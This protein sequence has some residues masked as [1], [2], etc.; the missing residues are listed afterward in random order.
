MF[1]VYYLRCPR[2]DAVKYV[3]LTSRRTFRRRIEHV[4]S[5]HRRMGAR[6]TAWLESLEPEKPIIETQC[7]VETLQEGLRI[8]KA[9]TELLRKR[10]EELVNGVEEERREKISRAMLSRSEE[11]KAMIGH[12]VKAALALLPPEQR[13]GAARSPEGV[14]EHNR[15][16]TD[17]LRIKIRAIINKV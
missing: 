15:A 14:A 1:R 4:N 5:I 17:P 11:Y 7:I 2:T 16:Y 3:G 6:L 9:L 10:G 13:G 12:R 8:E